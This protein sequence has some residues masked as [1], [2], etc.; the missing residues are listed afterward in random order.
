MDGL[1]NQSTI[2]RVQ[3]QAT[4]RRAPLQHIMLSIMSQSH[5]QSLRLIFQCRSTT[6]A[7][8]N[9]FLTW[10]RPTMDPKLPVTPI[11]VP[12]SLLIPSSLGRC[13]QQMLQETTT[14]LPLTIS[15]LLLLSHTSKPAPPLPPPTLALVTTISPLCPQPQP[16]TLALNSHQVLPS[17]LL[18]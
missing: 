12:Q 10:S 6:L 8:W 16:M 13:S 11:T 7:T 17:T 2:T 9:P 15:Q 3:H 5:S 14:P 18:H 4:I 1:H